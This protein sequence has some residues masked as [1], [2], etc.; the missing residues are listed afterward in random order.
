MPEKLLC[1]H[2]LHNVSKFNQHF[3]S[4][5]KGR[6]AGDATW[7]DSFQ[8]FWIKFRAAIRADGLS[9]DVLF[10]QQRSSDILI[11]NSGRDT[12]LEA[13]KAQ[14]ALLASKLDNSPG[15]SGAAATVLATRSAPA[16]CKDC[17]FPH[18][19]NK[20]HGCIGK[21]L[22]EGT[23]SDSEAAKAFPTARDPAA[24]AQKA[25][26]R[27]MAHN[28]IRA[29]TKPTKTVQLMVNTYRNTRDDR[30]VIKFDTQAQN[31]IFYDSAY[32]KFID[33]SHTLELSTIIPGDAKAYTTG[34]GTVELSLIDGTILIIENAHL[35]PEAKH[36][37]ISTECI[38]DK[39]LVDFN[40]NGLRIRSSDRLLSFDADYCTRYIQPKA[41]LE[42]PRHPEAFAAILA[43]DSRYFSHGRP[44][45]GGITKGP[46]DTST[47]RN[48]PTD[49][50]SLYEARTA[51]AS[52]RLK[53]LPNTTDAPTELSKLPQMPS[54]DHYSLR[55]NMP[56]A[57]APLTRKLR[58]NTVCF[59]LQGP[60][61]P[62]THGDNRWV[63]GFLILMGEER[64]IH[65]EFLRE[66]AD[67]PDHLELC[68]N[69]ID[70]PAR[71]QLYTDNEY[72]LNSCRVAKILKDRQM[73]PMH[74]SCEYEPWQNPA[75]G[76]WKTLTA[77]SR[78]FLL[79][80][81]GDDH[82]DSQEYW[83]YAHQQAADVRERDQGHRTHKPPE[84][85]VLPGVC[86]DP[87]VLPGR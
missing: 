76:P 37:V 82:P 54:N 42:Q 70:D 81:F 55:A 4:G 10:H 67:F 15:P 18:F 19:Q 48:S 52:R 12:E 22:A 47:R 60:F 51:L 58:R 64:R 40:A 35:Y 78:Q 65:L 62:S 86:Q 3:V 24:A 44:C 39:A 79:R 69:T 63:A 26:E 16:P 2:V 59:D 61:P 29:T 8:A 46:G 6:H 74:N 27:Y 32:F 14:V 80:G 45:F 38:A 28:G 31:T 43:T 83:P 85:S 53:A 21:A 34:R 71:M 11:T 68:L 73:A 72:V 20:T 17:G 30:P 9:K 66:K 49:M 5:Y 23:I 13:L 25:K 56:K 50:G 87:G 75:E 84:D 77:A 7:M 33:T 41:P 36:N 1:F 57:G